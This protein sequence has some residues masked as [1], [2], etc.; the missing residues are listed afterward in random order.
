VGASVIIDL[1]RL[2]GGASEALT[3]LGRS[4]HALSDL[5]ADY[6][7]PSIALVTVALAYA[8]LRPR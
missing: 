7:I 4:L 5:V 2:F 6:P 3:L 8:L 1:N